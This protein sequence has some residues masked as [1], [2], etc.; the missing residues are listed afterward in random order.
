MSVTV[1]VINRGEPSQ[2]F[3][4]MNAETG[5]ILHSAPNNWKTERGAINWALKRGLDVVFKE[6]EDHVHI[7]R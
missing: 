3:G 7:L 4:L 6:E 1:Y 5:Q 2:Y